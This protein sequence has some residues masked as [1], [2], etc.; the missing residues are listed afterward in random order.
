MKSHTAQSADRLDHKESMSFILPNTEKM[1]E[2][3]TE[4]ARVS[5]KVVWVRKT[6][7]KTGEHVFVVWRLPCLTL[8]VKLYSYF[9]MPGFL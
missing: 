5:F 9:A 7:T 8:G 6:G 3:D 2:E 1:M 4:D